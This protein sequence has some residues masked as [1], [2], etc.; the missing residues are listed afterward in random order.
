MSVDWSISPGGSPQKRVNKANKDFSPNCSLKFRILKLRFLAF[1]RVSG[2]FRELREAHR[3]HFHLSCYLLVPGI[4]SYGQKPWGELFCSS[5][6]AVWQLDKKCIPNR[7]LVKGI[8]RVDKDV[9]LIVLLT[10]S[11]CTALG[12]ENVPQEGFWP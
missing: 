4:T 10:T 8:N 11:G 5:P 3:N 7:T 1:P 9:F 12:T 6:V 2:G